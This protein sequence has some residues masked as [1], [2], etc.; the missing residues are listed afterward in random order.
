MKA[1]EK[2]QTWTL[3][4]LPPRKR[5]NYDIDYEETFALVAKLNIVRALLSLATNLDWPL[6]QFD[7]KNAFLHSE[8]TK[9]VYMDV[10]PG[11]T[12]ST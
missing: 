11:Y 10:S 8:L 6:H 12:T 2:N 9:E 1:P 4:I 7:V 3:E 5:T